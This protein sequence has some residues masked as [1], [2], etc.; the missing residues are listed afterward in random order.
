MMNKMI[1]NTRNGMRD[2]MVI[3]NY[4]HQ[5]P[6]LSDR[7]LHLSFWASLVAF[8]GCDPEPPSRDL[9]EL[10]ARCP[11]AEI[12]NEERMCEPRSKPAREPRCLDQDKQLCLVGVSWQDGAP[13][14]GALTPGER[15]TLDAVTVFNSGEDDLALSE[16]TVSALS[17]HV[18][19]ESQSYPEVNADLWLEEGREV[20]AVDAATLNELCARGVIPAGEGCSLRLESD[21]EIGE[22]AAPNMAQHLQLILET[23]RGQRVELELPVM[24]VDV[25]EGLE[26]DSVTFRESSEDGQ[27]HS[28]DRVRI[29]SIKLIH[30][31]FAPFSG[32][33]GLL[34]PET[35]GVTLEGEESSL[36]QW[37]TIDGC[38]A[39]SAQLRSTALRR[40]PLTRDLL[41]Q[42]NVS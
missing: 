35:D 28:G 10:I 34:V 12:L 7:L 31:T 26:V 25:A 36:T 33:R 5:R 24:V 38:N 16:L 30:D 1:D 18:T 6:L 14:L 27:L 9:D 11:D 23:G 22:E 39:V 19:L 37:E 42:A 8:G 13:R 40:A 2:H 29:E 15:A 17:P 20:R 32:L 3:S 4:G 21:F 41:S